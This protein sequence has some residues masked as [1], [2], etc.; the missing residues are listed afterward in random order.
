MLE[1]L[2][3]FKGY[4]EPSSEHFFKRLWRGNVG[5]L[6]LFISLWTLRFIQKTCYTIVKRIEEN[7]K[8]APEI[9][10]GTEGILLCSYISLFVTFFLILYL[11]I[12]LWR[13][14][15]KSR[16]ALGKYLYRFVSIVFA[17][18]QIIY[19]LFIFLALVTTM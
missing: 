19:G 1:R 8:I 17:L 10:D 2:K 6:K 5:S 11:I 4:S 12:P 3:I 14:A 16:Y 15:P 13:S 18:E 9:F 7:R